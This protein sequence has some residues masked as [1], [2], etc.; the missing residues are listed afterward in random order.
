MLKRLRM[1]NEWQLF[2]ALPRAGGGIALAWWTVLLLRGVLPAAFGIA[3]GV[4]IAAVQ[5]GAGVGPSVALLGILFV[6]LQ[7]LAPL[8]K[9]ISANLGDRT[10]SDLHDRLVDACVGP[11]G[12][13]HLESPR[14]TADLSVARDFD[15]GNMGPPLS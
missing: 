12:I 1:R 13:A 7:V 14:L 15:L 8:H 6:A 3:M 5:G 4:V 10:A 11:P 2:A 9:A